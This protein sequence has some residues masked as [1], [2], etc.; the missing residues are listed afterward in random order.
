MAAGNFP[1][2]IEILFNKLYKNVRIPVVRPGSRQ[3][4]LGWPVMFVYSA[5]WKAKLPYWDALPFSI[6]LAKYPDGF[7]GLNLHYIEW[8]KRIQ[9]A[10]KILKAAK[11]KK[12]ITYSM[13]K[14]AWIELKLPEAL[15]MLV[16]RRYLYSNVMSKIK[17]F[18]IETYY[19]AI[20]DIR[21]K[22]KK[23]TELRVLS[24]IRELWKIH[25]QK[26]TKK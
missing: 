12:R 14:K 2:D 16:I 18:D 13:I 25:K 1:K 21:P 11:N 3:M 24:A 9:L 5:K 17:I 10:N 8:T 26:S 22:F 4:K 19:A 23:E 6:I 7:L 15:L 20:K